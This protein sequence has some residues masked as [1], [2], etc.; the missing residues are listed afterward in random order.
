MIDAQAMMERTRDAYSF[1]HYGEEA[2]LN[3]INL[4]SLIYNEAEVEWILFSKYMRWAADRFGKWVP[5]EPEDEDSDQ[6]MVLDGEEIIKYTA[7]NGGITIERDVDGNPE[8]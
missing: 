6:H 1:D 8:L 4:L 3:A 7:Y 5:D 2:W